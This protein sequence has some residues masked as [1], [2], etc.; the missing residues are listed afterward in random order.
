[1]GI[2]QQTLGFTIM[3]VS[4]VIAVAGFLLVGMLAGINLSVERQRFTD[5]VFSTQS[6]IQYQYDLVNNVV[7]NRVDQRRCQ[8]PASGGGNYRGAD[9]CTVLGK[10]LVFMRDTDNDESI[11]K[12]YAVIGSKD[13]YDDGNDSSLDVIKSTEPFVLGDVSS[14]DRLV[15]PWGVA[16]RDIRKK[17]TA[18]DAAKTYN[19]Y[20]IAILR[21][22]KD[23]SIGLYEL[24]SSSGVANL[25]VNAASTGNSLVK[26][27]EQGSAWRLNI[28]RGGV[29]YIQALNT[30]LMVCLDDD[31]AFNGNAALL[32]NT[33]GSKDGVDVQFDQSGLPPTEKACPA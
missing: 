29:D 24:A 13:P 12:S 14:D 32:I 4:M 3:E 30:Q 31:S 23:G 7:N 1:M 6:Y 18:I 21:S 33:V 25:G 9:D 17:G 26:I 16:M 20:T 27:D 2:K 28:I 10:A 19:A 8:D 15:V 22:P 11:V 5:G